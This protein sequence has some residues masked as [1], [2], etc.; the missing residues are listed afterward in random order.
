MQRPQAGSSV[1]MALAPVLLVG[2]ISALWILPAGEHVSAGLAAALLLTVLLA[3]AR[4]RPLNLAIAALLLLN[5]RGIVLGEGPRPVS[6][7]DYLLVIAGIVGGSGLRRSQWWSLMAGLS[8]GTAVV[9]LIA[10][11][12]L[13]AQ[14]WSAE[15]PF[16]I[17]ILLVNQTAL[18]TGMAAMA[19]L[20]AGLA[21]KPS[22]WR[23]ILGLSSALNGAMVVATH[24]RAGL[25]LIPLSLIGAWLL[26]RLGMLLARTTAP[27]GRPWIS[28]ALAGLIV[29]SLILL[30]PLTLTLMQ[31][32]LG[33]AKPAA[34]VYGQENI[35]SD[36]ARTRLWTCYGGVPLSGHNRFIYGVGYG[37]ARTLCDVRVPGA[38]RP[39][40]HAHNLPLQIWAETGAAGLLVCIAGASSL[41]VRLWQRQKATASSFAMTAL[42]LY[43]ILFN[44]VELG[45]LKVPLLTVVFGVLLAR[46][47]VGETE[48]G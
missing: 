46:P 18:L 42:V 14:L 38:N 37:R 24:S 47:L 21:A 40:T 10:W 7:V 12:M 36:Q 22:R 39:L 27:A 3:G 16:H 45:M 26:H 29:C 33:E 43:P 4:S 41:L 5:L 1:A 6:S 48:P 19:G 25:G 34:L 11:P 44:L 2:S 9:A 23:W 15:T 20:A 28:A 8:I 17:G 31:Q 13:W 30:P 32:Q 35:A